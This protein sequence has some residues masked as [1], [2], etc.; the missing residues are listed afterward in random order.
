MMIHK[1]L[2]PCNPEWD[3]DR[4]NEA[5]ELFR[6]CGEVMFRQQR[7]IYENIARLIKGRTVLEAG[8][9]NGIGS[10]LLERQAA[11]FFGTDKLQSNVD[12]ASGLYSWISFAVWDINEPLSLSYSDEQVV[13]C[14]EVLEHV[15]NPKKAM[16]N[17]IDAASE[18]VW[19]S[20]PNGEAKPR[21]PENPFHVCEYTPEELLGMIPD[22][23]G[24]VFCDCNTFEE[25]V[26]SDPLV[27]RI[28]K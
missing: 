26:M 18:E 27:L 14:I 15:A 16:A 2:M 3:Q 19:I 7:V 1:P 5:I 6:N 10:A 23:L 8:C 17:L 12:F 4:V 21:P 25:G 28:T 22:G 13:V 11:Y 24:V 9:G 20:T